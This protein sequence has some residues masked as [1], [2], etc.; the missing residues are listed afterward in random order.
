MLREDLTK[1]NHANIINAYI[2]N[3]GI[4]QK[5]FSIRTGINRTR[6]SAVLKGQVRLTE[7]QEK[8]LLDFLESEK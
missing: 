5:E 8:M 6:V 1:S 3:R 7:R 4:T 2:N